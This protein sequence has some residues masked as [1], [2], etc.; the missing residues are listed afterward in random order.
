MP[1]IDDFDFAL[2]G[3]GGNT[4]RGYNSARDRTNLRGAWLV[5]GSKNVF[6]R[7]SG[8]IATRPGLKRRGSADATVADV[9]SSFEWP[10]SL[11]ATRVLRVANSKLQVESDVVTAG[12]YVWY[13][14]Q[15]SLTLTRYVFDTVWDNTLKKDFLVFVRGDDNLFRWDG[16]IGK[17]VSTTATT[18]VLNAT[19]VSLGFRTSGGSLLI[20]GNA[21]T[22][23]AVSGSTLTSVSGDPTGEAAD[24]VVLETP[25]TNATKPEADFD[26]DFLRVINNQ[27]YIGSRSSRVIFISENDD[28]LDYT[29][30]SP[31]APGDPE[32]IFLDSNAKGIGAR[33]GKAHI[34]GG[35]AELYVVSFN[36]ITVSTTLT[37]QT[38]VDKIR[39]AEN[40]AC[41][42]HEF[43]DNVGD[44]IVYLDRNQQL[45]LY[46]VVRNINQPKFPSL[47]L[48]VEDELAEEDFDGGHLRA[49]DDLIYI[50]APDTGRVW[51]H[52]T[53][54]RVN[55]MG[56]VML[57]RMWYA[58]FIWNLS[59]I[60]VI[61]SVEYGHSNANPQ[62]YQLWDTIQWHDDSPSDEPLPYDCLALFAYEQ[63]Q[64][65][66]E[67]L[68]LNKMYLE[69]YISPGSIVQAAVVLDYQGSSGLQSKEINGEN[70]AVV[71]FQGN[72]GISLGDASLGD[73]PL[74]DQTSEVE[75][76]QELLPK[77][78]AILGFNPVDVFEYQ[79]R[80]YS[81][82]VDSRWELICLGTNAKKTTRHPVEIQK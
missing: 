5:R 4:F 37:E 32:Q 1:R 24:S 8:T 75:L 62:I 33:E 65:R 73:N 29:V 55:E 69:G 11:A 67:K 25:I 20:N 22:Y 52:E 49:V 9:I 12:T 28:Y 44:D 7:N 81:E 34:F 45:R 31:R 27:V 39:L 13:D 58:P 41:L 78:R 63:T 23:G 60:A 74:G 35:T 36:Q 61:D 54:T 15:T 77:F 2:I 71:I 16:G 76:D 19:A 50:T 42:D 48:P 10:T 43:I 82:V 47:S 64:K 21:Y 59:R 66:T 51:I 3:T 79:M 40:E 18:I 70:N 72:V 14:L 56:N 46:G 57:E 80:V 53:K 26:S 6:K 68:S 17:I 38:I 30:P